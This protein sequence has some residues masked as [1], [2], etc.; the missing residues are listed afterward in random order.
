VGWKWGWRIKN[1]NINVV[2]KTSQ[3]NEN[4][5]KDGMRR[6]CGRRFCG[7]A[8]KGMKSRGQE[9]WKS[10]AEGVEC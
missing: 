4:G 1:Q 7:N 3:I 9:G 8:H 5:G 10:R 6:N 2:N